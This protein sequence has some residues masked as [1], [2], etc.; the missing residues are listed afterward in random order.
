MKELFLHPVPSVF[1]WNFDAPVNELPPYLCLHFEFQIRVF[2]L[3]LG[4]I[5]M[6]VVPSCNPPACLSCICFHVKQC[7][8]KSVQIKGKSQQK[9]HPKPRNPYKPHIHWASKCVAASPI[10]QRCPADVVDVST[11][12]S[13]WRIRHTSADIY[14]RS[15]PLESTNV[16]NVA[17]HAWKLHFESDCDPLFHCEIHSRSHSTSPLPLNQHTL[18]NIY[19]APPHHP[20]IS[21]N[22][23]FI[24]GCS[25]VPTAP[26]FSLVSF[27][28]WCL[29]WDWA[30]SFFDSLISLV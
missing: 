24:S 20:C 11:S 29:S 14:H 17:P 30:L 23:F 3:K 6:V 2:P 8:Y 21:A 18:F 28:R 4:V 26:L 15:L 27:G 1:T 12:A 9:T 16:W 22:P 10:N 19:F 7:C 25:L 5:S 13:C